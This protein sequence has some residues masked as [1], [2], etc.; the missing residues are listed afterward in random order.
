[1]D[2][3][4]FYIGQIIEGDKYPDGLADWVNARVPDT[5]IIEIEPKEDGTPRFQVVE[6]EQPKNLLTEAQ[7]N[8][9][10]FEIKPIDGVFK[11]GHFRKQPK[12]YQ[13]AVESINTTFNAVTVI[14]SLPANYL[15]FYTKPD[16][17]KEE[18]CTEEWLLANQFKNEAMTIEQFNQFYVT[19][20]T[21]W[22]TQEHI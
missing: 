4:K 5:G 21:A 12:G 19:F 16:F 17:T 14:G 20:M 9:M 3:D 8:S 11:G 15:T 1:M 18:E 10:F 7:F 2:K 6:T 13:S 22:N